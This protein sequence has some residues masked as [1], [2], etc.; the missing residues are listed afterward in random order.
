MKTCTKCRVEKSKTEFSA[1][2]ASRDGLCYKCKACSNAYSSKWREAN[3][4]EGASATTKWRKENPEKAAT[5]K[6]A[7]RGKAV[8]AS[9]KWNKANPKRKAATSANWA[10]AHPEKG[11]ANCAKRRAGKLQATPAWANQ[12]YMAEIYDLAQRRTQATGFEWEVDHV[13]PLRS[14]LVCG[15]HVEHNL[16]VIPKD[17]N[18]SKSNSFTA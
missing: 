10:K 1:R 18:R 11:A 8:V 2:K 14:K 9:T 17:M 16:R 4:G 12:G 7:N 13:V 15:L 6:K 5:W 3:P